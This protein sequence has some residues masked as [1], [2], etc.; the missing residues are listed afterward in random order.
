MSSRRA[1]AA[2]PWHGGAPG[3]AWAGAHRAG[4]AGPLAVLA[5]HSLDRVDHW[6]GRQPGLLRGR[7]DDLAEGGEGLLTRPNVHHSEAGLGAV[8]DVIEPVRLVRYERA[9]GLENLLVLVDRVAWE[10]ADCRD[11]HD[12]LLWPPDL[13]SFVFRAP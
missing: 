3:R 10:L 5:D 9:A 13:L 7:A 12:A 2:V 11:S 6:L 8:A 4:L 1:F